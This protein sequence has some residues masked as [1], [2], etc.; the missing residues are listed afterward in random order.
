MAC[1]AYYLHEGECAVQTFLMSLQVLVALGLLNVWLVRSSRSTPYRGGNAKSMREEFAA[2]G[3]P[4]WSMYVVGVLK[5]G[6]A[7][8]LLAAVWLPSLAA[9]ATIL[10][11]LLMLGALAMHAKVKDPLMKSM[12]A[13]AILML[14]IGIG[15]G[16]SR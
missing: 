1:R 11:G 12:P 14:C 8:A 10:I 4:N 9:P 7:L 5:V 6:A 3:L 16:A 2:Y 15:V 13:A